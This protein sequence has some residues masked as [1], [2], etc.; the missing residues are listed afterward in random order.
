M[1]ENTNDHINQ[2]KRDIWD[3]I[4][5][6]PTLANAM[7]AEYRWRKR[8]NQPAEEMV[9]GM[10]YFV[11]TFIGAVWAIHD[12]TDELLRMKYGDASRCPSI[13]LTVEWIVAHLVRQS[14][15]NAHRYPLVFDENGFLVH[16]VDFRSACYFA[17]VWSDHYRV[18]FV[19]PPAKVVHEQ[20]GLCA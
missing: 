10:H 16:L 1:S 15:Q 7:F 18:L 5:R 20:A 17:Q 14:A 9:K 6:L 2:F 12:R 3:C 19:K 11:A 13:N 8:L 4:D